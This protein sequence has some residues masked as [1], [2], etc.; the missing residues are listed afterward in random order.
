M[1]KN[2]YCGNDD[3]IFVWDLGINFLGV[4]NFL[5][6]NG[7]MLWAKSR[8]IREKGLVVSMYTVFSGRFFLLLGG[9]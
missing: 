8:R 5:K 2:G 6:N 7:E 3:F 4:Q 9:L 1:V